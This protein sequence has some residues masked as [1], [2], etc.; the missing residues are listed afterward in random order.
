M[1]AQDHQ[2]RFFHHPLPLEE[3]AL[4][5]AIP[6]TTRVIRIT[7]LRPKTAHHHHQHRRTG[8]LLHHPDLA[9]GETQTRVGSR[10]E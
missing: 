8:P 9:Q 3:L 2:A 10:R 7:N 5:S 6:I 1:S 4:G